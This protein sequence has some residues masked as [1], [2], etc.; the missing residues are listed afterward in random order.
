[1]SENTAACFKEC[2]V[3]GSLKFAT[4]QIIMKYL[5]S[6]ETPVLNTMINKPC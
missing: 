2:Y 3:A 1:M 6:Y 4:P 5:A